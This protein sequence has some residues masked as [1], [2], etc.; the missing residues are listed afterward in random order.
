MPGA[1]RKDGE[2]SPKAWW[3]VGPRVTFMGRKAV[4]LSQCVRRCRRGR[5][6]STRGFDTSSKA[7]NEPNVDVF[8]CV[9]PQPPLISSH[10]LGFPLLPSRPRFP[11]SDRFC[12]RPRVFTCCARA[13]RTDITY[14][15]LTAAA[16]LGWS[17][18]ISVETQP[19]NT[20]SKKAFLKARDGAGATRKGTNLIL[21]MEVAIS[22][23]HPSA[24]LAAGCVRRPPSRQWASSA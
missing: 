20:C 19:S 11:P 15:R 1:G 6:G 4:G 18:E 5:G 9:S 12:S 17:V 24:A 22:E 3:G 14:L 16:S 2:G 21:P 13:A 8:S 7:P 10:Y 23:T